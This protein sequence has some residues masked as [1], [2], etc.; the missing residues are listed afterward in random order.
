MRAR[1]GRQLQFAVERF[2]YGVILMREKDSKAKIKRHIDRRR[3]LKACGA[4]GV[5]AIAGGVLQNK[6][7]ITGLTRGLKK[8]SQTR[9]AMGTIVTVTAVHESRDLAQEAIGRAYERMDALI[10]ILNRHDSASALSRTHRS[11]AMVDSF[12]PRYCGLLQ[13]NSK[14]AARSV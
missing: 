3:F 6:W 8:V 10:P 14:T 1:S 7:D 5:G 4:L 9:I 2:Q 12:Q 11:H 13:R